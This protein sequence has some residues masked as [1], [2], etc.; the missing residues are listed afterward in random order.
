M[1]KTLFHVCPLSLLNTV[2]HDV[3]ATSLQ[4]GPAKLT[5]SQERCKNVLHIYLEL[6]QWKDKMMTY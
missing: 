3:I 2:L 5:Y 6:Y 1:K 4:E